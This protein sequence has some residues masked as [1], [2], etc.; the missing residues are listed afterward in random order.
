VFIP[1]ETVDMKIV[2]LNLSPTYIDDIENVRYSG[3]TEKPQPVKPAYV[4]GEPDVTIG[5]L[6]IRSNNSDLLP[7]YRPFPKRIFVHY[8][9]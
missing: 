2:T 1:P 3:T 5:M 7:M 6:S 4:D 8:E 9:K